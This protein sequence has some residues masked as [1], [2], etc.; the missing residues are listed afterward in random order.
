MS[1]PPHHRSSSGR[2]KNPW[3][4]CARPNPSARFRLFAFPYAGGGASVFRGWSPHAPELEICAV[5][6]PGRES[7]LG[8]AAFTHVDQLVP[9]LADAL[10]PMLDRPYALFGH[11]I[12][13]I[14]VFELARELRRRAVRMPAACFMS[15]RPAPQ[16]VCTLPPV[17]HLPEREFL[18]RLRSLNGTPDEIMAN[19]ELMA[20]L[21]PVLRADFELAWSY[22]Y[23][24]E[25][26]LAVPITAFG[27]DSDT[28][29]AIADLYDW[30]SHT[31]AAFDARILPGGHF[32]LHAH[33]AAIMDEIAR[34]LGLRDGDAPIMAGPDARRDGDPR[35]SARRPRAVPS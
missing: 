11:S 20:L 25:P 15:G 26:P 34:R 27:G 31:T 18:L 3:I 4:V 33:A 30:R 5:Q 19:T 24:E 23:R 32:F 35:E 6:L 13:A 21:L 1:T 29:V 12:G 10:L 22:V 2:M 28:D 14:Q 17:H 9:V 16:T 7:R 8:E